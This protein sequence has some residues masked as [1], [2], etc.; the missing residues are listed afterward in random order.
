MTAQAGSASS[1]SGVDAAE[2]FALRIT[3]RRQMRVIRAGLSASDR[4]Q[5]AD[6][7][8]RQAQRARL[9]KPRL[10]IAIYLSVRGE[11]DLAPLIERA[12]RLGCRLYLPRVVNLRRGQMEFLRFTG[13]NELRRNR[14]GL[15]E[16]ASTTTRIAPRKLDL[17]FVPLLA[18]D[19]DGHRLGTGGGFYDRRFAF[20][21][22]RRR[23]RKPRLI[24]VGYELQRVTLVPAE[25]WDIAL[26]AVVTERLVY[27]AFRS[28]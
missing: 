3:L 12:R 24:G 25:R 11:A 13:L 16:P 5:A 26:D 28:S 22:S 10:N 21:T 8:A 19:T 6:A 15:L 18:F 27:R 2:R 23:W 7:I 1:L 14:L 9:L 17:V 20:L 4:Q